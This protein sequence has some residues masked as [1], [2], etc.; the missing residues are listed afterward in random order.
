M[1]VKAGIIG[2]CLSLFASGNAAASALTSFM[3]QFVVIRNGS[4]LVNDGFSDNIPPPI[5]ESK[6]GNSA[7]PVFFGTQGGFSEAGGKLVMASSYG[8]PIFSSLVNANTGTLIFQSGELTRI[9]EAW[10]TTNTSQ[11][12]ANTAGLK[13][14]HHSFEVMGLFD[15]V[16]PTSSAGNYGIG[17]IDGASTSDRLRLSVTKS[18][19]SGQL[20][21]A[22]WRNDLSSGQ[23]VN[24]NFGFAAL[25]TNHDQVLLR[26]SR[27][28]TASNEIVASYAY[29]DT[30]N[31]GM[32]ISNPANLASLTFHNVT[33]NSA[34]DATIFND[35]VHTLA[36]IR[37]RTPEERFDFVRMKT[38]SPVSISQT[39]DVGA[40]PQALAFNY[41]F[42][43]STGELSILLGETLLGKLSAPS[44]VGESFASAI[45]MVDGALLNQRLTLSL[46][47][48]GPTGS[49]ILLDSI[50]FQG[51]QNGTF[52]TGDLTG[53]QLAVSPN[54][55]VGLI[56]IL[57]AVPEPASVAM[58]LAGLGLI[59]GVARFRTRSA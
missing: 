23:G 12:L 39:V 34:W 41:R 44:Q 36:N 43:T 25:E 26:L 45:Y 55:N 29:L 40:E 47:M 58:M 19:V 50:N 18:P 24:Y 4:V 16:Q 22:Y 1:A 51:L 13:R 48:D 35:S 3:D 32:D 6:Y 28:S 42:E 56:T 37:Q 11:N 20:G 17:L 38:G 49:S 30:Q 8:L 15:L 5:S 33:N 27:A 10:P 31:S 14:D 53:W 46:V 54:G 57:A 59:A 9:H 7:T 2:L 21:I 52:A